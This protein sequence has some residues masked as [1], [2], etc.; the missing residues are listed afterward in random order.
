MLA[1]LVNMAG[2]SKLLNATDGR[3]KRA[4]FRS[5]DDERTVE[6]EDGAGS[7][8][9]DG[10]GVVV[11]DGVWRGGERVLCCTSG[12]RHID[13]QKCASLLIIFPRHP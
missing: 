4:R 2:D 7:W 12:L 13:S 6:M 8:Q 11:G 3:E 5:D 9:L 1:F 10:Q